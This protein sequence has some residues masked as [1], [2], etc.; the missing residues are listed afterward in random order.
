MT[1]AERQRHEQALDWVRRIQDPDFAD[2]D[3]HA[4]W[5][6][7]D[8]ANLEAFDSA[9]LLIEDATQG[10]Q[11]T[12]APAPAM[13]VNDNVMAPSPTGRWR[14]WGTGLGLAVAASIAGLI[15]LPSLL[16]GGGQPYA[17][18]TAPGEQRTM[19]LADGTQVALNGDSLIRL[20][21]AKPRLAIV[22]RGEAFFTVVHDAEHPFEVQAGGATFRDVGTAFD[23]IRTPDSTEMAVREGAVMVDPAGMALRLDGGQSVRI[24]SGGA[25]VRSADPQAIGS[26]RQGRLLYRDALLS[27]VAVDLARSIG[28]SVTVDGAIRQRR[29]SGVIMIDPDRPR[30]FHRLA[31]VMD[32]AILRD[33]S[34][35]RMALPAR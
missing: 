7:A 28:Q 4:L 33:G 18:G 26:W 16:P 34:G 5:L 22:E 29:F 30:M 35:W 25:V 6:E 3:G 27:D 15:A 10:L 20:D 14:R 17:I 12:P 19:A 1:A 24:A 11:P 2:W 9:S 8:P 31:A 23:V 32:V 21:K 13:P